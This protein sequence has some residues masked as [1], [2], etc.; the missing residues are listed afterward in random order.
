MTGSYKQIVTAMRRRDF[1]ARGSLDLEKQIMTFF[2]AIAAY[3]TTVEQSNFLRRTENILHP[4]TFGIGVWNTA[5]DF[6]LTDKMVINILF[7]TETQ[8]KTQQGWW[9]FLQNRLQEEDYYKKLER[10]GVASALLSHIWE[11]V[12][13]DDNFS[14]EWSEMKE[15]EKNEDAINNLIKT[16]SLTLPNQEYC[17]DQVLT[18]EATDEIVFWLEQNTIDGD[19]QLYFYIGQIRPALYDKD[20][21]NFKASKRTPRKMKVFTPQCV[22]Y[23]NA[24]NTCN[25]ILRMYITAEGEK[26]LKEFEK[27]NKNKDQVAQARALNQFLT[28]LCLDWAQKCKEEWEDAKRKSSLVAECI[29]K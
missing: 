23:I 25:A 15:L 11:V 3:W 17:V 5:K 12:C 10:K 13:S 4:E 16:L 9:D 21:N 6:T 1:V 28:K 2:E 7:G 20:I 26:A 18:Q 22:E 27:Q 8:K 24:L 29:L 14:L 19:I